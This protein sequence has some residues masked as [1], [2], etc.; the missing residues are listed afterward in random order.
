MS[1]EQQF[2][3]ELNSPVGPLRL[4]SNGEALV[5]V[6]FDGHSPAPT[7]LSGRRDRSP[8]AEVADQ[9][10]AYFSGSRT[11]FDFKVSIRGT[12]FQES[13]WLALRQIPYGQTRSY[14]QIA[15]ICN[16]R[17]AVRAVGAAIGRNPLSIVIP[18]HRVIGAD[19]TMTGF[20]G[21][22]ARKE[23]LLQREGALAPAISSG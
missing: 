22:V 15:E 8:F 16:R 1:T 2:E 21:G 17:S 6:Y 18:C 14:S 5:G 3:T 7:N 13:I 20:A 4:F 9:L 19:G 10:D 12:P 11:V 23:W